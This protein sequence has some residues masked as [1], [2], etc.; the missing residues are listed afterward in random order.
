LVGHL[1]RR[2]NRNLLDYRNLDNL[3]SPEGSRDQFHTRIVPYNGSGD[4]MQTN[5]NTVG[6]PTIAL[7]SAPVPPRHSQVNFISYI[8][9]TG[10]HRVSYLGAALCLVFG[11]T[12]DETIG[13]LTEEVAKYGQT[14]LLENYYKAL[15]ALEDSAAEEIPHAYKK[16]KGLIL[17]RGKRE[18]ERLSSLLGLASNNKAEIRR[19]EDRGRQTESFCRSLIVQFGEEY[20]GLCGRLKRKAAEPG[21]TAEEKNLDSLVPTPVPGIM[22]TSAYFGNYYEKMLGKERLETFRLHPDFAY[23]HVGYAEAHNFIDGR[24]TILEIYEA[25]AAEL[26]SEDYPPYH[27]ISLGEVGSYMKMLEA[28]GVI[29]IR[30]K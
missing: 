6:I 21:L 4:E 5:N 17:N 26:W 29:T 10:L 16:G 15:T 24:R 12:G 8:D 7:G 23:G 18:Q 30:K 20:K 27:H 13:R 14:L 11:W 9:P 22:G 3:Y 2:T 28:S 1:E 19:I 25:V